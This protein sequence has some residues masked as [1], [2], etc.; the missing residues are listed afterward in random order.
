MK[1]VS[2]DCFDLYNLQPRRLTNSPCA[3]LIFCAYGVYV[4]QAYACYAL[5]ETPGY[6]VH[7]WN[8]KLGDLVST[9]F[10]VLLIG[11]FYQTVLPLLKTAILLEWLRILAPQGNRFTSPFWWGCVSVIVI[12]VIWGIVCV[13]LLNVQC[14]PHEAIWKIWMPRD[15]CFNLIPVQLGSGAIQLG[16]DVI[17]L[18]LPQKTIWQLQLSWKKRLGVSVIFGLGILYVFYTSPSIRSVTNLKLASACV[19]AAFRLG[20]TV[21]YGYDADQMYTLGPVVFWVLA[22]T[23]CGFFIVC[24]PCLPK[25]LKDKGI[26]RGVKQRLGMR[27]TT[28]GAS[29]GPS[30]YGYGSKFNTEVSVMSRTGTTD[31]YQKLDE[32]GGGIPMG[33]LNGGSEEQLRRQADFSQEMSKGGIVRTTQVAVRIHSDAASQDDSD[34]DIQAVSHYNQPSRGDNGW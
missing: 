24:I 25:I 4:G 19:A 8:L 9:S 22:E 12:Q 13:I 31:A 11:S 27:V 26:I 3:V 14:T 6:F 5:I 29:G 21:T 23:T 7:Q 28:A 18:L 1:R 33:N 10:N 16:C 17:M 34:R 20:V 2:W 32:E 15:Q 30:K